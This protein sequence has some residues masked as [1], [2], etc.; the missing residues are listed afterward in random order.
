MN[1]VHLC[2]T[3]ILAATALLLGGCFGGGAKNTRPDPKYSNTLHSRFYRAWVQPTA[4]S[5]PAGRISVP[6]DVQIDESGRVA[7]FKIAKRS[8]YPALDE[9]IMAVAQRVT[10]VPP[11]P[12]T[13]RRGLFKLRIFFDLDVR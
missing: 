13:S 7:S 8:G 3:S 2:L 4:L 6:V 5:A 11:P 9:S 1:R 10:Q 12:A